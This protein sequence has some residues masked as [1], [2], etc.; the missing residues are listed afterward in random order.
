[1]AVEFLVTEYGTV[2]GQCRPLLLGDRPR[3]AELAEYA[4]TAGK[5][6]LVAIIGTALLIVASTAIGHYGALNCGGC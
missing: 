3:R 1:M 2:V 6:A 4:L 5:W